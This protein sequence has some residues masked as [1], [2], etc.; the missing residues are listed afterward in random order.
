MFNLTPEDQLRIRVTIKIGK[1][2]REINRAHCLNQREKGRTIIEI[3]E[4]L[5]LTPRTVINTCSAYEQY[6]LDAALQDDPRS[7]RPEEH[8]A[9]LVSYIVAT[10]CSDPPE[11]FDRWTLDLLK[12]RVESEKVI[13]SI[14]RQ[15]IWLILQ[16]HDFK[17]WQQ[18]MWCVPNLNEEYI[19]RMEKV[20][21]V[22]ELPH[23][24]EV[25]VVCVDEKPVV[26]HADT[27]PS[28]PMSDG[29]PKRVDFE[30]HRNGAAN[31]FCGV[32]PKAGVFFN[33][34]TASRKAPEFA[35]FLA[36]IA[37]H[38]S[39]AKKII[40]VMDNL[41]SH[42]KKSLTDCFGKEDGEKLWDR[43]HVVHTPKHA[44]WLNQAEIAIGMYQRQ[45]LGGSR[46]PDIP[47]LQK[48]TAFWNRAVNAKKITIN[49]SF[50]KLDAQEKFDYR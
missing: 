15:S 35:Q 6:G 14:S 9:R 10:V 45:C 48:K 11:G 21:D 32:E 4:N 39:S 17:P 30:Y 37:T 1:S 41:S 12:E 31:V 22:Y 13:E 29:Q 19:E 5:E 3:A 46:I 2:A 18:K 47:N 28:T 42:K 43:F 38:Y 24:I 16:E 27:R 8:D 40:L 44:S 33:K 34:V 23:N 25:P 26:L 50:T 7:G 20:L 36:E 49:W